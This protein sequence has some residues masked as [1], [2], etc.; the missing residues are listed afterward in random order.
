[1]L[2]IFS[3]L[4][5]DVFH[6]PLRFKVVFF[7]SSTQKFHFGLILES[8]NCRIQPPPIP[9]LV[10]ERKSLSFTS[11][12]NVRV[13]IKTYSGQPRCEKLNHRERKGEGQRLRET[14]RVTVGCGK[15]I[16]KRRKKNRKQ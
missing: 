6:F 3:F 10:S 11:R 2:P 13:N 7:F 8:R 1:M 4:F 15:I 5:C 16:S 14:Q 9:C 12:R